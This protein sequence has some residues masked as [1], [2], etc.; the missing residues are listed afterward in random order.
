M[1]GGIISRY[2]FRQLW[3]PF[4]VNLFFFTFIFLM[5]QLLQLTDLIVNHQLGLLLVGRMIIYTMP[6]FLQFIIPMSVMMAILLTLMR[7]SSDNEILALKAAGISIVRL[8]PPIFSFALISCLA[9]ALIAIWGLPHG[10]MAARRL[11]YQVASSSLDAAIKPRVFIDSF[12]RVVLYIN[13]VAPG[14]GVL[15]DIFIEDRRRSDV[16]TTVV[17]PRGVLV[18]DPRDRAVILRLF[19]GQIHQVDID[20]QMA[21]AVSFHTYD[22]RLDMKQHLHDPA[23]GP[24]D[25]EEMSLGEL[26][27]YLRNATRKDAQYYLTL[28]EWHKKFALP[29]ACLALALVS[30][31]LGIQTRRSKPAHAIGLGLGFFLLYYLMLS[32][33][34]VFGEAGV[35]PP[36]IG[37]W[38]PNAVS[39]GIGIILLSR[40]V[41]EKPLPSFGGR[42]KVR[43]LLRF[44]RKPHSG[45]GSGRG[46]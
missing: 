2:V 43:D 11:I 12:D 30:T 37:M 15:K 33:G 20:R 34:W 19:D 36:L 4:A 35:Y 1:F 40:K 24:K 42:L 18:T 13:Q 44:F 9:T 46:C 39:A 7:M 10:R 26:R 23:G 6:F 8:L 25:E 28:M 38:L 45:G 21:T 14:S 27:D 29:V 3:A 32:A 17:A 5:T 31:A 22:V 41:K 16:V